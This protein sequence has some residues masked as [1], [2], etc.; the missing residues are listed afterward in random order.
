MWDYRASTD[1]DGDLPDEWVWERLR[2][3]RDALLA[4]SDSMVAA[5]AVTDRAAWT[6]YRQALRD[7]PAATT[8]PREAAWPDPPSPAPI[9]GAA[10]NAAT[11][12]QQA[13]QALAVNRDFAALASPNAAQ[14]TAQVKALT[15][16][17][18][19][20]I[21]LLLGLLDATD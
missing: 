8:D 16:Q 17:N 13:A 12:R 2:V 4:A 18:S 7:L 20:V 9:A 10:E 1:P 19:G 15:R 5:D 11:I 6:A 3:R 21:R 14:A